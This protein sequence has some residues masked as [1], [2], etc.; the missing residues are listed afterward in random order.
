MPTPK[1]ADE[2]DGPITEAPIHPT[3]ERSQLLR[4]ETKQSQIQN[5]QQIT[6]LP[7]AR[8]VPAAQTVSQTNQPGKRVENAVAMIDEPPQTTIRINIGRVEVRA[9]HAPQ[10]VPSPRKTTQPPRLTIEEY[11]KQRSEGKV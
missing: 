1:Q 4:P 11:A 2:P 9:V 8:L 7:P 6:P 3:E 10:S 5:K